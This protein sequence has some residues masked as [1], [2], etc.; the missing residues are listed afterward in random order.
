[1]ELV[2][3]SVLLV[4]LGIKLF[5]AIMAVICI[6]LTISTMDKYFGI[7]VKGWL[8]ESDEASKALYFGLRMV[9]LA[10]LFGNIMG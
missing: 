1:M 9:A 6:L 10:I 2:T 3:V 8:N 7:D 4:G 5:M